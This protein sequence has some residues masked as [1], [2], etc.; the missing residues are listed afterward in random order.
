MR[1]PTT[2]CSFRIPRLA[3]IGVCLMVL[4]ATMSCESKKEE[5]PEELAVKDSFDREIDSTATAMYTLY[6]DGRMAE[7]VAQMESNDQKPK[8]Y[9]Q[10]MTILLKQ[11]LAQQKSDNGGPIKCRLKSFDARGDNYGTAII[12]VTFKDKSRENVLLQ[13][14]KVDGRWR[15]R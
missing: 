10:Q 9:R 3:A 2:I 1:K 11:R 6:I 15:L 13:M 4:A 14:V 5:L 8:S 12:E 7:Y